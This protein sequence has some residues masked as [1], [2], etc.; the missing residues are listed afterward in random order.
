MSSVASSSTAT[1]SSSAS[2]SATVTAH[3]GL[4]LPPSHLRLKLR[5]RKR[6]VRWADDVEDN[7]DLGR[8]K[9]KSC[10]IFHKQRAFGDWSSDDECD[11]G[12]QDANPPAK[13]PCQA[14]GGSSNGESSSSGSASAAANAYT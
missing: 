4:D 5:A 3:L 10:C 13:G 9:S 7:E 1:A 2:V 6:V 8:K 11:G 12:N 14:G